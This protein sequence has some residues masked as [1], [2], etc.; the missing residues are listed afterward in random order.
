VSVNTHFRVTTAHVFLSIGNAH[1]LPPLT[2]N[3]GKID[4]A[5]ISAILKSMTAKNWRAQR[6][7]LLASLLHAMI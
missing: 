2:D 7:K 3:P 4:K 6:D 1:V 5:A